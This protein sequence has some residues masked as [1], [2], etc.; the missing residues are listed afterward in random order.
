MMSQQVGQTSSER[1]S[2]LIVIT[3]SDGFRKQR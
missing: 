1:E 2:L 3:D